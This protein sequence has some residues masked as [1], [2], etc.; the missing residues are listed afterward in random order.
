[1]EPA[2]LN[3]LSQG[4]MYAANVYKGSNHERDRCSSIEIA[5]KSARKTAPPKG[6]GEMCRAC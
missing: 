6:G 3:K 1:M 4:G 2:G 5:K